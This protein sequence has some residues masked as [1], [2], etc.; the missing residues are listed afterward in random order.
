MHVPFTCDGA[1]AQPHHRTPSCASCGAELG[2]QSRGRRR[3][4]CSDACRLQAF[5]GC[6]ARN[7]KADK[8]PTADTPCDVHFVTKTDSENNAL[9]RRKTPLQKA[10][11][12]WTKVNDVTWKLTDGRSWRTPASVGQWGGYETE[13][14]VAWAIDTGWAAGRS[15]WQ[16]YCGAKSYGPTSFALAKQAAFAV[17]TG[18]PSPNGTALIAQLKSRGLIR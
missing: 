16:A 2:R 1:A 17:A 18:A 3:K 14:P 5:R 7:E 13:W 10:G 4:Y 9:L 15:E 8:A 12:Y 11:L 6:S